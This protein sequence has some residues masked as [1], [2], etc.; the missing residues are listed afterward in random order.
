MCLLIRAGLEQLAYLYFIVLTEMVSDDTIVE[1]KKIPLFFL[2]WQVPL[3]GDLA[4]LAPSPQYYVRFQE[5]K[6]KGIHV[7]C[8]TFPKELEKSLHIYMAVTWA[9]RKFSK[10]ADLRDLD[11]NAKFL[12]SNRQW[13]GSEIKYELRLDTSQFTQMS[14]A[15]HITLAYYLESSCPCIWWRLSREA[16]SCSTTAEGWPAGIFKAPAIISLENSVRIISS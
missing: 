14:G 4:Y 3:L 1:G 9:F 11:P 6:L 2:Q 5:P 7:D 8:Q 16:D 12:H 13:N 15:L 10:A